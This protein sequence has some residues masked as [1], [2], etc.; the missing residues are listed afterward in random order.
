MNPSPAPAAPPV[1]SLLVVDDSVVQRAHLARLAR[2]LGI[3]DVH[4]AG[5]GLAA[6]S[7]VERLA[8][9]GARPDALV[10]DLEMPVMDGIQ[11][12]QQLCE[13]GVDAPFIVASTRELPL[14][15]SVLT[16][17][18]ELG[19]PHTP[20]LRKPY[21]QAELADALGRCAALAPVGARA[22]APT[23]TLAL[24]ADQLARAIDAG[25][26]VPHFQPKVDV[27]TGLL[28]GVEAL[29]RWHDADLG[30]VRPDLFVSFAEQ[31]GLIER[32]TRS[33]LDQSLAQ[34]ARWRARGLQPSVAVNLSPRM[35][36][37]PRLVDDIGA[38]VARHGARPEQV[39]LEITEGSLVAY[40]GTAIGTLARLR[41]QGFRLSIDDYG[42][43]FSSMQQLARIPFTEL[44]VD[45]SFVHDAHA[46]EHLR[47]M[48][49]SSIE[50]AHRLEL[51]SV[52][53]GVETEA[54]WR[55]VQRLGCHLAQGWFIAKA[56]PGDEL[57]GWLKR[58]AARLP[59]LRQLGPAA[60]PTP[61][62]R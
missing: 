11:L 10:I 17:A 13:R 4:E 1:R 48:L 43:G 27:R 41:M 20:V 2:Q 21:N 3:V 8:A 30:P 44:K 14:L 38:L 31:A 33:V 40:D 18:R 56:M 62:N 59:T 9:D 51:T 29:A 15:E 37:Q 23:P 57:H 26:I 61:E 5:D 28:R 16:M 53:E 55:L 46:H 12:I 60:V 6:L 34:A 35:L 25:Q 49:Q 32:L 47:V 7:L 22:G 52:V 42:T 54:D 50:M 58:H 39:V 24:D 45:R 36:Q 19:R